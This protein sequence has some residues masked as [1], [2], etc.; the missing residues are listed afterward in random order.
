MSINNKYLALLSV[1][2]NLQSCK[3]APMNWITPRGAL[4]SKIQFPTE[5]QIYPPPN[6][7][8]LRLHKPV[9][10]KYTAYYDTYLA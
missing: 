10:R 6:V 3:I 4:H 8:I 5:E 7:V 2:N 9:F 1:I